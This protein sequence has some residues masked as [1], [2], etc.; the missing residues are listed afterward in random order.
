MKGLMGVFLC[1]ALFSISGC[2]SLSESQPI[3]F[4]SNGVRFTKPVKTWQDFL[5]Q[6]ILMQRFDY[7]CGSASLATLMRYYFQDNVSERE[8]LE[9]ILNSLNKAEIENRKKEGFS[10]L[11]LKQFAERR[12]YQAIGLKLKLSALPKLRGPVLVHLET[13]EY[14]HFAVLRGVKEDRVFLADPGRG[15]LRMSVEDFAQ[16]WSGITLV[17]I[18]KGFGTPSEYPLAIQ[19]QSPLRQELK[20]A[21]QGLYLQQ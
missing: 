19:E 12:G 5:R 18:K 8:V 2:A 21:R 3:P 14:K 7:S 15:N 17:L 13:R 9:D 20:A 10:M 16:E 4:S 1:I 6:H 11:D